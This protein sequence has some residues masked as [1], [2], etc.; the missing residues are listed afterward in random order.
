MEELLMDYCVFL[1]A[2]QNNNTWLVQEWVD[3]PTYTY[4]PLVSYGFSQ[5][6]ILSH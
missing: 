5:S 3:L 6:D 2:M 1:P 4:L